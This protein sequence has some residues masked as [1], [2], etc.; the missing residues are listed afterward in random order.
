MKNRIIPLILIG[1]SLITI[2]CKKNGDEEG[3]ENQSIVPVKIV[4]PSVANLT[5]TIDINATTVFLRKETVRS[6]FPGFVAKTYK[7]IGDYVHPGD[8]IMQIKT[9]ESDALNGEIQ[10]GTKSFSGLIN[11]VAKSN[12]VINQIDHY[13]GDY[14]QEG[15]SLVLIANPKSLMIQ[16]SVPYQY[17][18]KILVG[19]K[20]SFKIPDG[21]MLGGTVAKRIP[22]VDPSAQTETYLI[23]VEENLNL[24]ENLNLIAKLPINSSSGAFTLPRNAVFCN[25]T[26]DSFWVMKLL[27]DKTAAKFIVKKGI[28]NDSIIQILSPAFS[29]ADRFVSDGGYGL[30]DTVSINIQK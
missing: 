5:E 30:P 18:S 8:I 9:K 28:E 13:T 6:T 12:G 26:E 27:D 23:S 3:V 2:S 11:V 22:S 25:E 4:S 7:E 14:V 24:P 17:C 21:H 1:I 19:S 16:M 29:A 10:T 15:E 20:C